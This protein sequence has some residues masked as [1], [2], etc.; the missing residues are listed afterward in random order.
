M[1]GQMDGQADQENNIPEQEEGAEGQ[2]PPSLCIVFV[3]DKLSK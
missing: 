2:F 1:P 3:T